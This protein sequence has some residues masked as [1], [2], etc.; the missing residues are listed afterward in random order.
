LW[1]DFANSFDFFG[2]LRRFAPRNDE[3]FCEG[4][5]MTICFQGFGGSG[6]K[7][8]TVATLCDIVFVSFGSFSLF[9]RSKRKKM[10]KAFCFGI[11]ARICLL[12]DPSLCSG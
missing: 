10:N 12:A 4:L 11:K 2:L 1:K 7:P 6:V 9:L 8:L 3:G 5:G